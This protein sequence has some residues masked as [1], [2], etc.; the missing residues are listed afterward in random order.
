MSDRKTLITDLSEGPVFASLARFAVPIM[1]A[2]L[3]Q[4]LYSMVD[5]IVVGQFGGS[6]GLS[7]VGIGGQIQSLFLAVGM[8]FANGGQIVISQQV[9]QKSTR[10]SRTVGTMLTM[11]LLLAIIAGL[12]GI[13]FY[14]PI[15]TLMNTPDAAWDQ[16]VRYMVIC[17]TGMIF[18]Y[19]YNALCAILR[20]M[21]ESKLP[22]VFV[23]I[24][25]VVNIILDLIFVGIFQMGAG[26]AALATVLAQGIAFV[27]ALVQMYRKR[28]AVGFDFRLRSF[29]IDGEQLRAL[30]RLGVP[31]VVQSFMITASITFI[32]AQV[33]AYDV[34][35]SAVDSV[36]GKLNTVVNVVTGA[37]STAAASMIA[38]SFAAQKIE[39]VKQTVRACMLICMIWFVILA[40]CYLLLPRQI[41]SIFT[42]EEAVL[43]LAPVYLRFAVVWLLA[44]CSMN[45]PYSLVS[46][47]GFASFN[48]VVGLLDGVVARIG[49][50]MLLGH[51]MGL[52]G[53]WLGNG[54]AGFVTTILM[55]V[56]Y[57]SGRWKTRALVTE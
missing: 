22:M 28:D 25:S 52:T 36:G 9:G 50:S 40:T 35:A 48:L 15:L 20:G 43:D 33:N 4:A 27:C 18:I 21:G 54:L 49:L 3:L 55:G 41:F 46:G 47:V 26:G 6:A 34:V 11:E 42:S 16:A 13:L 12:T 19:G 45:A 14:N 56:Y 5:L 10:I 30:C 8:G 38:Q 31:L 51:F 2:N 32:N 17:S 7:A 24:A 23:G 57:L 29:K 37:I 1:L 44:L 39:R 53:F